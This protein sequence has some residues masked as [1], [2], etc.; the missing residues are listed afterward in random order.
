MRRSSL[1]FAALFVSVVLPATGQAPKGSLVIVGGGPR[2]REIGELFLKQAGGQGAK[3]LVLP[4]ASAEPA[5]TG[6]ASAQDWNRMG[7]RATSLV[8]TKANADADSVVAAITSA[9][10]IWFPGGVQSRIMDA[11]AGT[12]AERALRDAYVR[13]AV[14][15]GTSAGAA[16]MSPVMITGDER[17]FGGDRPPSDSSQA[18][19]TIEMDNIVTTAGLGLL[20]NTIVDQHFIRR[21]R[22]NRLISLVL[23]KPASIGI[24]I[25][26]A[27]ALVV[28][29][30]GKWEIA[31]DGPV[32]IYDARGASI[33][34]HTPA[35][36]GE[37]LRMHVLRR[38]AVFDP[39]TGRAVLPGASARARS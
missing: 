6:A 15:G 8:I 35:I 36:A 17:R 26:E 28:R 18:F 29:A 9:G 16:I 33:S 14:I 21:R 37:G 4:M 1:L 5:E 20:P 10:G 38:G 19:I 31:G 7:A 22:H 24:G 12:R 11:I 13:G 32:I 27:T 25:D 3:V 30:D 23:E 39:A 34:P 2:P